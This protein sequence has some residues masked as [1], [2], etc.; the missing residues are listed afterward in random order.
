MLQ[1]KATKWSIKKRFTNIKKGYNF[2]LDRIY[3]TDDYGYQ[4]FLVFASMF[5]SLMLGNNT[6]WI[7]TGVSPEK[8]K[9]F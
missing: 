5:N 2:L 6:N 4:N 9:L 1:L 7:S 3:F 8:I